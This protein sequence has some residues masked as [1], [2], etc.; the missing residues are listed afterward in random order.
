MT[1][2]PGPASRVVQEM[3]VEIRDAMVD[4]YGVSVD[5]AEGRISSTLG[6]WDLESEETELML[7]HEDPEH[8]A[9]VV[10]YGWGV[11]FWRRPAS[12]LQPRPWP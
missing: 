4:A 8:W 1:G 3:L 7:G 6:N 10:Y 11:D 12:E 5:E 9:G 2:L